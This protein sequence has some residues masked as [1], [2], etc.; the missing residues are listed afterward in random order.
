VVNYLR[1]RTA[2]FD[3]VAT[4]SRCPILADTPSCPSRR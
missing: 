3:G 2:V 4:F 1:L